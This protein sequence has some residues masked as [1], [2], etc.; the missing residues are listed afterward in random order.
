ML[1][2]FKFSYHNDCPPLNLLFSRNT[3]SYIHF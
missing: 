3:A 2:A 1:F